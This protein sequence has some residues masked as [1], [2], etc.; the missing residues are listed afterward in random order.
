MSR[1]TGLQAAWSLIQLFRDSI[2][3][4]VKRFAFQFV[5]VCKSSFVHL[6]LENAPHVSLMFRGILETDVLLQLDHI[7]GTT[8]LS[9][10]FQTDCNESFFWLLL[11]INTL[12]CT[13]VNWIHVG[14][15]WQP[16]QIKYLGT[17][18]EC[19]TGISDIS[20]NLRKFYSQFNV[21]SVLG[22]NSNEKAALH[23]TKSYCLSVLLNDVKRGV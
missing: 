12:I 14:W 11:L 4:F 21:I 17:Y 22:K 2:M 8:Y 5:H 10:M 6:L 15:I 19:K 18:T 20:C 1:H 23:L 9:V 13:V 3:P 16:Q 7:S